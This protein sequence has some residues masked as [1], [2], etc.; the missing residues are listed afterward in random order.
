MCLFMRG[1]WNVGQGYPYLS[2]GLGRSIF[3]RGVFRAPHKRQDA[4][5]DG[6]QGETHV[7]QL[8]Q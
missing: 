1:F 7:D 8:G 5:G 4:L 2:Y 3:E 6:R